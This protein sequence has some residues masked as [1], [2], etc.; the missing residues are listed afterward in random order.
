MPGGRTGGR[1]LEDIK[2]GRGRA[3]TTPTTTDVQDTSPTANDD[4]AP[5]L[6]AQKPP[7]ITAGGPS[8]AQ[9]AFS[10][11]GQQALGATTAPPPP[12]VESGAQDTA[13]WEDIS[14]KWDESS[15]GYEDLAREQGQIDARR[16]AAMNAAS[17][18][19]MGGGF[20]TGQ[21]QAQIGTN[22]AVLEARQEHQLRGAEMHMTRL[23]QEYKRA[24][25][26][27]DRQL[28]RDLQDQMDSTMMSVE[29]IRQGMQLPADMDAGDVYNEQRE[30]RGPREVGGAP[31]QGMYEGGTTDAS[32]NNYVS[33]GGNTIPLGEVNEAVDT[34]MQSYGFAQ[35]LGGGTDSI[36]PN[37]GVAYT[38][39]E[40]L[41]IEEEIY[42]YYMEW[43][44]QHGGELPNLNEFGSY[45]NNKDPVK[46]KPLSGIRSV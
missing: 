14:A 10:P 30:A 34:T 11:A 16:A 29:M 39:A 43:I 32:G 28:Q 31:T 26:A 36:N 5:Q 7:E 41:D 38:D 35:T 25:A 3:T 33:P 15:Q 4:A 17:G 42:G 37:T 27:G 45:V 24:E 22:R 40:L 18:A 20:Q 12:P 6:E 44:D 13:M 8:L 19:G 9:T 46:F 1:R 2:A 21:A 23:Q